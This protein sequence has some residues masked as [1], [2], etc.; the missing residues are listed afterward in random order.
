MSEPQITAA[1]L[2]AVD[3]S[4]ARFRLDSE[5]GSPINGRP[6]THLTASYSGVFDV[7]G[8]PPP[9][10]EYKA[11][12]AAIRQRLQQRRD[13]YLAESRPD[14]EV[15]A[16]RHRLA[17]IEQG[18]RQVEREQRSYRDK[19]QQALIE[20]DGQRALECEKAVLAL[21]E[22]LSNLKA[23]KAQLADAPLSIREAIAYML[24]GIL[25][26][27]LG[28]IRQEVQARYADC[29]ARLSAAAAPPLAELW[30][31]QEMRALTRP[32]SKEER[33][34]R[35]APLYSLIENMAGEQSVRTARRTVAD[36]NVPRPDGYPPGAMMGGPARSSA[37]APIAK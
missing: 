31:L 2:Q 11:E 28:T 20:K 19:A 6:P 1:S 24:S 9:T 37:E 25:H 34:I 10:N 32:M 13:E 36:W 23:V 3:T 16:A 17:E 35:S 33:M 29:L 26:D 27:E 21:G 4:D 18:I 22:R 8:G 5:K 14:E 15:A 30:I 7:Q 12:E